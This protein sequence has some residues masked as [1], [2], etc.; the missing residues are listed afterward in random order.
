MIG[1]MDLAEEFF[2]KCLVVDLDDNPYDSTDGIHSASLG[3]IWN[4]LIFGFA[5]VHY[6]GDVLY[7]QPHIPD[8]WQSMEFQLTVAGQ[9][10]RFKVTNKT[11]ELHTEELLSCPLRVKA[12]EQEYLF[13]DSLKA[14][15]SLE[16]ERQ[17][18]VV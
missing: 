3:G 13:K 8:R 16:M 18:E 17:K 2:D 12:G 6:E 4:C 15:I 11:V 14:V 1:A 10:I 9:D 5:G 7:I